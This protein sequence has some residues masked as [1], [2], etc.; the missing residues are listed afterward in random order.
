VGLQ[1][2]ASDQQGPEL[3]FKDDGR[4][5]KVI[6]V[7]DDVLLR[8]MVSEACFQKASKSLRRRLQNDDKRAKLL[9][10]EHFTDYS[11]VF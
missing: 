4:R 8:M 9:P 1:K 7:E 2:R 6:V 3:I 5:P 11:F 10:T